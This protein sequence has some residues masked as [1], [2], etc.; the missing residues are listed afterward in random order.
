MGDR[1]T[2]QTVPSPNVKNDRLPI[3][4]ANVHEGRGLVTNLQNYSLDLVERDLIV[5][6]VVELRCARTFVRCHLLGVFQ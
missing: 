2:E 1:I 6:A 4:V 5:A 3:A